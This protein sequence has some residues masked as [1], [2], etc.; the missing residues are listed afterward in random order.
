LDL[1]HVDEAGFA[2]TLPISYSWSVV[3]QPRRVPYEAPQG[4]RVNALGAYFSHGPCA[5]TLDFYSLASLPVRRG[6][7]PL[8]VAEQAATHGL[9]AEEVGKI[10]SEVFL[11]FLWTVAGRPADG[12]ENWQR[13]RPLHFVVDNYSVH[14]SERVKQEQ[15]ALAAAGI[16]LFYLPSY[17][18]ELSRMEPHWQNVKGA[19]M[20]ERSQTTAGA[21]KHAVDLALIRKACELREA[22]TDTLNL[23]P[24]T[25]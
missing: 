21:L 10:D 14:K 5:G 7:E 1:C 4:R 2:P 22:Y 20:P 6:K 15:P 24:R 9:T 12:G 11:G 23:L 18:P 13:E 17:S 19:G 25:P 3:G 8:P 16:Q